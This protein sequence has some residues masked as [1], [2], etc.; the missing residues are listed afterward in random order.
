MKR[1]V[2]AL[3]LATVMA[4][5]VYAQSVIYDK[6]AKSEIESPTVGNAPAKDFEGDEYVGQDPDSRIQEDLRRDPP[7]DR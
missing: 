1:I 4:S 6:A 7:D 2:T 5:P 3:A